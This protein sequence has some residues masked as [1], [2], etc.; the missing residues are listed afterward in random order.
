[1][2]PRREQRAAELGEDLVESRLQRLLADGGTVESCEE[3][4]VVEHRD[5]GELGAR[6]VAEEG[7]GEGVVQGADG[8]A[9]DPKGDRSGGG[10]QARC[11]AA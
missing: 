6:V 10:L 1:V 4:A 8:A 11:P 9:W 5:A 3:R 2:A 7:T